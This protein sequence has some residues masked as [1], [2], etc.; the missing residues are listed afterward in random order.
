MLSAAGF[1]SESDLTTCTASDA[2]AVPPLLTFS[3][4][5]L[6]DFTTFFS[7]GFFTTFFLSVVFFSLWLAASLP[8]LGSVVALLTLLA[9]FSSELEFPCFPLLA[10][11]LSLLVLAVE[12]TFD[13]T[14]SFAFSGFTSALAFASVFAL[15][16]FDSFFP[17]APLEASLFLSLLAAPFTTFLFFSDVELV[18]CDALA[19]DWVLVLLFFVLLELVLD[20]VLGVLVSEEEESNF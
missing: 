8:T 19:F 20:F 2:L 5:A 11:L 3:A 4:A 17:L 18:L 1:F 15:T 12:V 14:P 9:F 7:A 16:G 13:L 10:S 6:L